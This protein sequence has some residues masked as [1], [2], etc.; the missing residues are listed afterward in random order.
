MKDKQFII[1][2]WDG[3]L[4]NSVPII[5]YALKKSFVESGLPEP[6]GEDCR[7]IIGLGFRESLDHLHKGL[8]EGQILRIVKAY[9]RHYLGGEK[10]GALFEGLRDLLEA[11]V[12]KGHKLGVATGKSRKGLSRV[13]SNLQLEEYFLATRCADETDSKPSPKMLHELLAETG[14]ANEAAVMIGDTTFDMQMAKDC[15]IDSV[16]VTYGAHERAA[17]EEIQ[18]GHLCHTPAELIEL[19][20]S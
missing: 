16:A 11:L 13:L 19:L 1:F 17:L 18:P 2:D 9:R 6:A 10:E 3:T 12:N 4:F 14:F 20:T 8:T 5:E 15:P 7:Y